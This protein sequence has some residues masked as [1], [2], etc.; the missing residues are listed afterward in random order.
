MP[1]LRYAV[2][3]MQAGGRGIARQFILAHGRNHFE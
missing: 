1:V 2:I 3:E